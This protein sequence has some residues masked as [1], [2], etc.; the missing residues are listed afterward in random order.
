MNIT[1]RKPSHERRKTANAERTLRSWFITILFLGSWLEWFQSQ[2]LFFMSWTR[3]TVK[4]VITITLEAN[5]CKF[6][7]SIIIFIVRFHFDRKPSTF[8]LS[9]N[10]IE[11]WIY[12]IG[13]ILFV[14]SCD[15]ELLG[16]TALQSYPG[17]RISCCFIWFAR[18]IDL[19][20][21]ES[22]NFRFFLFF[23][24]FF[25]GG[26][27]GETELPCPYQVENWIVIL[28]VR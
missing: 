2:P 5:L 8:Q 16:C 25:W 10:E 28:I 7:L 14:S 1:E 6:L 3:V 12:S 17:C 20:N 4:P 15:W 18:L 13:N 27:E 26:G 9:L 11:V 19:K 23:S 21:K 24:F 22:V